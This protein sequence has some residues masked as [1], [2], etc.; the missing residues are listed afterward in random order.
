MIHKF[1]EERMM[2]MN[3]ALKINYRTQA[4]NELAESTPCPRSVN[5][6]YSLGVNLQY[7]IGARYREIAELNQKETRS[8]SIRLAEKQME[9]KKR[10]D[11]A[12]SHHLNILIQ[13][14]YEQGGPVIEDPVSEET[15]K[16]INP[17]YNRL[18]SNFLKTLDE[19]T[20]KVRRGEMSIG[21]MET[22]IDR[23]LISM[24]GALGNLFGVGEM[25]KAFHDLVEI[26]ESLA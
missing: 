7:C 11:Q 2:L 23:E 6:V 24:Y 20:D 5:D 22:T 16:E 9:I 17:F 3:T 4:A 8:D 1:S 19:V 12:A 10:I 18:M 14:F 25:R 13:H 26:R 21:E 15:V